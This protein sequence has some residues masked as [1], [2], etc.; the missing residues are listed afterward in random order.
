MERNDW[1]LKSFCVSMWKEHTRRLS[2]VKYPYMFSMYR[3]VYAINLFFFQ[4]VPVYRRQKI[5]FSHQ[6]IHKPIYSFQFWIFLMEF[7]TKE[8]IQC[9]NYFDIDNIEI[10]RKWDHTFEIVSQIFCLS[11]PQFFSSPFEFYRIHFDHH[12][13]SQIS[14]LF[15]S[16]LCESIPRRELI[17]SI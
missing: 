7:H 9:N 13:S 15:Q 17:I 4:W 11:S 8:P 5:V 3:L 10:V 12:L 2:Q 14:H 1:F 16:I 6:S